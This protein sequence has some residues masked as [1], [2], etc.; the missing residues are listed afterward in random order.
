MVGEEGLDLQSDTE[1]EREYFCPVQPMG[2]TAFAR[3]ETQFVPVKV[4]PLHR[5]FPQ[6]DTVAP[7]EI[8]SAPEELT[9]TG[10]ASFVVVPVPS[11]PILPLP[12]A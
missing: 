3:V 2:N 9:S 4:T 8:H 10:E 6:N 1:M 11:A 7:A 12:M 5:A